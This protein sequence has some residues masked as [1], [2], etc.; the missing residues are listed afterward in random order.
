MAHWRAIK[1]AP[2]GKRILFR[3]GD[4][5]GHVEDGVVYNDTP[6]GRRYY[7]LFDGDSLESNPTEWMPMPPEP[8]EK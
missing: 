2:L 8:G 6:D 4:I 1:T 3:Y 5:E 7:V